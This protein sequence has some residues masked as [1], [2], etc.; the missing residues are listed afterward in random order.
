MQLMWAQLEKSSRSFASVA[1]PPKIHGIEDIRDVL[2]RLFFNDRVTNR[3]DP[4]QLKT[5]VGG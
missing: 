1:F 2:F 5:Q 3:I 4:F